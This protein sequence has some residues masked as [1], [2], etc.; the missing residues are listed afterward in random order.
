MR[1]LLPNLL[2]LLLVPTA[3]WAADD[4]KIKSLAAG[5]SI[6]GSFQAWMVTGSHAGRYHSPVTDNGLNPVVL[7]F[8]RELEG[9]DKPLFDLLKK[10]DDMIVKYPDVRLGCCAVFLNDAGLRDALAKSGDEYSRKFADTTVTKQDL[11]SRL[12]GAAKTKELRRV[13][14]ALDQ[15]AGPPNYPIDDKAQVTVIF[16]N[17]HAI[18]EYKTFGKDKLNEEDTKK[19]LADVE[20]TVTAIE[21]QSRRR[22]RK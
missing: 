3:A 22:T 11:E 4:A 2:A 20:K 17:Q 18:Q 19:I 6:P 8:A 12:K 16:Y 9:P 13:E 14:L 1:R 15:S 21:N 5:G 7:I 10:I